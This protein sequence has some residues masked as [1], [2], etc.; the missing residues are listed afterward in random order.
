MLSYLENPCSTIDTLKASGI[1]NEPS[2]TKLPGDPGDHK[3]ALK[4]SFMFNFY[5]CR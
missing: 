3:E 5:V 1:L 2:H 4:S